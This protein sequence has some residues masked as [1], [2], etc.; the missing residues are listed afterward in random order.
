MDVIRKTKVQGS[1]TEKLSEKLMEIVC[2]EAP[3]EN[4]KYTIL[5]PQLMISW[6][7]AR[8]EEN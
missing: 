8:Q 5:T 3:F 7:A 2:L 6:L 1:S 4:T